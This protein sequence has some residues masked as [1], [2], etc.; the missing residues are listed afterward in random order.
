[1]KRLKIQEGSREWSIDVHNFKLL[2]GN[3][4]E[5]KYQV[6]SVLRNCLNKLS[7]SEFA[8]EN[9]RKRYCYLNEKL[10][11]T[12]QW[13]YFEINQFFDLETD[14]KLGTKSLILKYLETFADEIEESETFETLKILFDS[15]GKEFFTDNT[16]IEFQNKTLNFSLD[17]FTKS[18]IF[19]SLIPII[20]CDEFSCNSADLSYKEIILLQLKLISQIAKKSF[21]KGVI[22]YC[23]IPQITSEIEKCLCSINL[24]NLILLVD[25]NTLLDVDSS[26]YSIFSTN[27]LDLANEEM[28]LDK[29]MELPFHI[30]KENLYNRFRNYV[31]EPNAHKDD[32]LIKTLFE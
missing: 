16:G 27:Y 19:K 23:S 20:S 28:V 5:Q 11:D 7:T 24:D 30:E 22:A 18:I 9:Q 6:N 8:M 32:L 4:I 21:D 10:I 29:I 31:S 3:N 1:M 17:T 15:F 12:K 2:I 13:K 26:Y 14:M 25:T